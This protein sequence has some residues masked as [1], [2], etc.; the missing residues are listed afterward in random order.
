MW[1]VKV[2]KVHS[3]LAR[4]I[5][6]IPVHKLDVHRLL[7]DRLV[8]LLGLGHRY[9]HRLYYYYKMDFGLV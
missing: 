7:I 9:S 8:Y 4:Y 5:E 3:H 1:G 6:R 2:A